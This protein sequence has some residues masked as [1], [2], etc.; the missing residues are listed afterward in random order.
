MVQRHRDLGRTRTQVVCRLYAVL[1]E[2]VPGGVC[3][4]ITAGQAAQILGSVTPPDAVAAAR[5]ELAAA[6]IDDLRRI[7]AQLRDT[8]KRLAAAVQ[9][10]GTSLTGLFGVGPASPPS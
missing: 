2:L 5:C 8:K 9:A 1:C 3:K 4:A 7:D 10:A 6:F